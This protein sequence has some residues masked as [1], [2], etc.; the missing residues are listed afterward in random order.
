M[1]G[2]WKMNPST[3]EEA[4]SLA[5]LVAAAARAADDGSGSRG[6]DILVCPP[7]PFLPIVA[8]KLRG[9]AVALG[10]QNVHHAAAGAYTGET[11]LDMAKSVGCTFCLVGH[12]ERRELF[13]ETDD[14]V[15]VKT[16][17]ILDA[18]MRAVVCVGESKE[19]YEAGAV[20]A[21]CA[22]QLEGALAGVSAEE[23][24][25]GAV[26]IAYEP[27]WAIGTGLTATPAI[28]QSVHAFIR[29][30]LR[31]RFGGVAAAT[32]RI[33]YGGSVKPDSVDELMQC[34]D[35]DGCLVGGASLSA[36]QFSRIFTFNSTPPGPRKLWAEEVVRCRNELG[37][38]PVWCAR[39]ETL[40]WVDAPGKALWSWDL[41]HEPV[42]T[43]FD[44]IVGM[45]A[46]S[47][48]GGLVLGLSDS[49]MCHY[50]PRT[51]E[52]ER[53]CEFEP[54]L[55]TRPNDGRVDRCGNLIIGSYN[56]AHRV[57]A[58]TI[59]GVYRLSAGSNRLDEVLGYKIRVSNGTCFT[60][61]GS[62]MFFTDS[63]TRRIYA[64][65]YDPVRGPS[66]R[67]RVYEL[68]AHVDGVPDGAQC[69]AEGCLWVAISGAGKVVRVNRT[70]C[71]DHVVEL[72]VKSP[73]SVTFGGRDL[74]TIFVT[75]RGPDG[76]SLYAVRAP[77]GIR[78]VREVPW[79]EA[80]PLAAGSEESIVAAG[81]MKLGPVANAVAGLVSRNGGVGGGEAQWKFCGNC[82]AQFAVDA[83]FCTECGSARM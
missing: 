12:S 37:E 50:D 62:V 1:A 39:T 34:P 74:D 24:A 23:M 22:R 28:A 53:L 68:P 27:V 4:A 83:R 30:W 35:V 14:V 58:E 51:G 2:T 52:F 9:T 16:R 47:A 60:P 15:G 75:T 26:V 48:D 71:V 46:L 63:P 42:K 64:F 33:Q 55:N 31:E 72:P 43:S 69:D 65:D 8:D 29:S 19:E 54:G 81:S 7:A 17:A 67:R 36:D 40:Y 78:G 3:A 25:S 38:S 79:G 5:A 77:E 20:R 80:S 10:A 66:N 41:V 44:E 73:T 56:N 11:S 13:G 57:D 32:V 70:G 6:C 76:G 18:E 59:G 82:G 61:D 21:V 49:G 45:V